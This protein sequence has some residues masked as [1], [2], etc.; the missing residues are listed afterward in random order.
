VKACILVRLR[1]GI[2]DVPGTSVLR[3]LH[4][5]GFIEVTD[6]RVGKVIEVELDGRDPIAA[7]RRL[8]EMCERLLANPVIERY[9][10]EIAPSAAAALARPEG[11]G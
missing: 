10:I 5:L 8:E 11:T 3:S 7:R 1:E 4:G 9:A 2:L 6:L